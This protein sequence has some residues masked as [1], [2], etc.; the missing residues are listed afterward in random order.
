MSSILMFVAQKGFRDEELFVPKAALERAGHKV[1]VASLNRANAHGS[2]GGSIMPDISA[3][4]ANPS[5]FDMVVVVGGPGTPTLSESNDVI[6]FLEKA[7]K[8][9]QFVLLHQFWQMLVF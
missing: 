7:N 5:F 8:W 1:M 6:S 9:L 4:E 3:H 2:K